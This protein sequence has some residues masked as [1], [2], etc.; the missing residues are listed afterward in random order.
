MDAMLVLTEGL[1]D[2]II[3]NDA[4]IEVTEKTAREAFWDDFCLQHPEC[5]ECRI[6]DV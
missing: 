4:L 2:G 3:H 6:Y 5:E 1:Q